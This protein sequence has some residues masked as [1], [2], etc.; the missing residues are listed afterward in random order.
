MALRSSLDI[1]HRD[2]L[3]EQVRLGTAQQAVGARQQLAH[4]E[5]LDDVVVRARLET[6]HTVG[7][8]AARRQHDERQALGGRLLAQAPAQLDAG[9]AGQHPVEDQ[10]VGHGLAQARLGLVAVHHG[11]D[12]IACGLEVVAQ[13]LDERLVVLHDHQARGHGSCGLRQVGGGRRL[14]SMAAESSPFGRSAIK[15]S[16][17]IT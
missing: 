4:R 7:L 17:V 10:Q 15:V 8:L 12:R 3:G 16:P 14:G 1:A 5:R 2:H 6:A 9:Q 11:L 13:Q